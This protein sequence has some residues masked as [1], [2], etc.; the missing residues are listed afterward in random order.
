MGDY[1]NVVYLAVVLAVVMG[2]ILLMHIISGLKSQ[3]KHRYRV[4]ALCSVVFVAGV[5]ALALIAWGVNNLGVVDGF[6]PFGVGDV[7]RAAVL[8]EKP[9]YDDFG[10][11]D[12]VDVG[13]FELAFM[14]GQFLNVDYTAVSGDAGRPFQ[15]TNS[16][17]LYA[18][19]REAGARADVISLP[20]LAGALRELEESGW[21]DVLGL[22]E[23]GTVVLSFAGSVAPQ[24]AAGEAYLLSGGRLLAGA[25]D[26]GG[27]PAL[28]YRA[29]E[30][31]GYIFIGG[32][33]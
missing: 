30:E 12:G 9:V 32:E 2:A 5:G 22:P 10:S 29:G 25:T 13:S 23:E 26:G 17:K 8:L 11:A 6:K 4:T 15:V 19:E 27:L 3:E 14:D 21:A 18:G 28:C 31:T 24:T 1:D 20:Q 7:S 33:L 16:G